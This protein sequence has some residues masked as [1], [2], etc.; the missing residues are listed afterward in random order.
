MRDEEAGP[1]PLHR[2]PPEFPDSPV[3]G[4]GAS[5][6]GGATD[7]GGRVT[8]PGRLTV[9]SGAGGVAVGSAAGQSC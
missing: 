2:R 7:I 4:G 5:N 1:A 6:E 8:G 9:R 3:G